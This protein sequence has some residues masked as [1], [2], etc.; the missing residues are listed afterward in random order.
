MEKP[1]AKVGL[2]ERVSS[3]QATTKE[4]LFFVLHGRLAEI[5]RDKL[6]PLR[7]SRGSG[8]VMEGLRSRKDTS[9]ALKASKLLGVWF[10]RGADTATTF[11]RWGIRP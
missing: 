1:E 7:L 4:G 6:F 3:Y 2:A 9:E 5:R 10:A 11:A 8:I